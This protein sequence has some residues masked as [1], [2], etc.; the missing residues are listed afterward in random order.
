M[1]EHRFAYEL[2]LGKDS[3]KLRELINGHRSLSESIFYCD[4]S[5]NSEK[6]MFKYACLKA[7]YIF[8][9]RAACV[10]P[11]NGFIGVEKSDMYR[12]I[13]EFKE[14]VK[15]EMEGDFDD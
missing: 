11:E 4:G 15:D 10:M 14:F 13:E 5:V 9:Y 2:E 3:I 12:T 6:I 7:A 1:S 8:L